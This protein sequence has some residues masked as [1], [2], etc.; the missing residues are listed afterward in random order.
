M[1]TYTLTFKVQFAYPENTRWLFDD[2]ALE[3][4]ILSYSKALAN[5]YSDGPLPQVSVEKINQW[6]FK[7]EPQKPA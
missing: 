3:Q 7:D 4:A 5:V 2:P 1:H 6:G